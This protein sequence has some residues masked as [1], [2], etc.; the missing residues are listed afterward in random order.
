MV[1]EANSKIGSKVILIN[2]ITG[3]KITTPVKSFDTETNEA[4]V[5]VQEQESEN[6]L[7]YSTIYDK[8]KSIRDFRKMNPKYKPCSRAAMFD[9]SKNKGSLTNGSNELVTARITLRNVVAINKET[10]EEIL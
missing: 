2:V 5:Y 6:Y 10:L 8:Y 3:C 9:S 4:V 7:E 1:I